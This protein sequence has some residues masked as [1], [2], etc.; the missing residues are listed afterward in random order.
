MRLAKGCEGFL[1]DQGWL[2]SGQKILWPLRDEVG[3]VVVKVWTRE[4]DCH[5]KSFNL[6]EVTLDRDLKRVS[7]IPERESIP[8]G[9][10]STSTC[11]GPGAGTVR[12]PMCLEQ[13][14]QGAGE[15]TEGKARVV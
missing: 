9:G 13:S 7:V 3:E 8:G 11:N 4:P 6:D 10:N 14:E 12:R 2:Q 5:F 15:D 1:D